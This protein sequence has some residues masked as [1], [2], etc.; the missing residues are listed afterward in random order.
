M[1]NAAPLKCPER[2]FI[3]GEWV[4]PSSDAKID[5]IAPATEEIYVRFAEAQ[6]ADMNRAVEAA[7]SAF[8]SGPWPRM[9]HGERASYLR[10]MGKKL[11]ERADDVAQVW[12]NE[13]G[14]LHSRAQEYAGGL[15]GIFEYYAELADSFAFE[16]RHHPAGGGAVGLLVREPVGVTAVIV[17]WNGPFVSIPFKIAPAMLAGCT[18]IIKASPEAPGSAYIMAE[19]AA[20]V[21]LPPGVVNVVTA[22]REVS[23]FLVRHPGVDKV[24]FTGSTAAGKRI[25]SLCGE[26]IA[27]YTLELGG[28]SAALILDDYDIEKAAQSIVEPACDMTGQVCSSLSRIIVNR[29]KH[30]QLVEA[31]SARFASVKVGDPFDPET[32]MGPI[33]MRRQRDRIEQLI[34]KGVEDGATLAVGGRRPPHLK[35][36]FFIEPTVFGNVSNSSTIAREE[37]FGPVLCVI[38]ADDDADA[39]AIANDTSYGLNNSV[40]T[41][42]ADRAYDV[43]RQLRS[44]TVGHNVW[45]TD[46]SIAFGGFKQSGIGREGGVEGLLPYLETKTVILE[47]MP[48]HLKA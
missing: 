48:N 3:G 27:R 19:I 4:L 31:L 38:A 16:E 20:A 1:M 29:R 7:R 8:D 39:V 41:N 47:D 15:G 36:G 9:S 26:R 23:E 17:P 5:V 12:P 14:I 11:S 44:G 2:F 45:R 32:Q 21:G 46:F 35:R 13:M 40:F 6:D 43:A 28:K 42:D 30:D 22:D 37:F 33:A 24:S 34:A 10:A 18:V 25:A